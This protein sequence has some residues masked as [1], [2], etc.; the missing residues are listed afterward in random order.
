MKR[1]YKIIIKDSSGRTNSVKVFTDFKKAIDAY[2]LE[3]HNNYFD[4]VIIEAV[5]I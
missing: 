5:L 4:K 2:T 3:V 1:I